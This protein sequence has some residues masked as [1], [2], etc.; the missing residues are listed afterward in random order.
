M[1]NS[2]GSL[3]LLSAFF[4]VAGALAWPD[5]ELAA[6]ARAWFA[7]LRADEASARRFLDEHFAPSAL[8]EA[9]VEER[10]RRRAAVLERTRGLTP[11]EV[12]ES[13]PTSLSVRCAAG[14]G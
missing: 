11:L 1:R 7:M 3:I 14:N 8:A 5:T 13:T 10:L 6:H 2:S 9:T 12:L 4:A